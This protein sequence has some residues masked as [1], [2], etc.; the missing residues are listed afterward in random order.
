[1]NSYARVSLPTIGG[2]IGRS[3]M[4][5]SPALHGGN[6]TPQELEAHAEAQVARLDRLA[7]DLTQRIDGT[8]PTMDELCW[9]EAARLSAVAY[10]ITA[11]LSRGDVQTAYAIACGDDVDGTTLGVA[12]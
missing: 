9:R 1:M 8:Y 7:S 6:L 3:R 5:L 10:E 12:V 4:T 11:A 2:Q